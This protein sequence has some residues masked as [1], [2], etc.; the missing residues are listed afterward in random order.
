M[1][2][3]IGQFQ[4]HL[5]E[6]TTANAS[7][8]LTVDFQ[9]NG[10][11]QAIPLTAA[12]CVLSFNNPRVHT[13]LT[14]RFIQDATGG[15]NVTLPNI[16]FGTAVNLDLSPNSTTSCQLYWN[17]TNYFLLSSSSNS[18]GY[19]ILN[20]KTKT[21]AQWTDGYSDFISLGGNFNPPATTGFIRVP[22]GLSIVSRNFANSGNL[23]V[24]TSS[25]SIVNT[26][27]YGDISNSTTII[28][29]GASGGAGIN[30][31][32]GGIQRFSISSSLVLLNVP[33]MSFAVAGTLNITDL[34]S[35]TPQT[36][37]QLTI[38]GQN[39]IANNSTGGILLLKGGSVTGSG[40]CIGGAV[41]LTSGTGNPID[42]NINASDGYITFS[43]GNNIFASW[44]DG[45]SD[46][47][48]LA[49]T[50][51]SSITG[52]IRLAKN[53]TITSRNFSNTGDYIAYQGPTTIVGLQTFGDATNG[54]TTIQSG[55][56][57]NL[58]PLGVSRLAVNSTYT[59][60]ENSALYLDNSLGDSN[61]LLA[62]LPNAGGN[63]NSFT[64][65][66]AGQDRSTITSRGGA[67]TIRT[68]TG[69]SLDP[70]INASDGY[71]TLSRGSNVVASWSD[72]YSDFIS[73]GTG[74]QTLGA[75]GQNS[76]KTSTTGTIRL[77][78]AGT[79]KS[80][81]F[82]N[83]TDLNAYS[84]NSS[85]QQIFGDINSGNTVI[86][87]SSNGI[88]LNAGLS[89]VA[90]FNL[91]SAAISAPLFLFNSN[92]VGNATVTIND[93]GGTAFFNVTGKTLTIKSQNV[94]GITN[95]GG[96][97][98]LDTGTGVALDPN[99][100]FV[101]GYMSFS[102][103]GVQ[104]AGWTDGYSDFMSFGS[105]FNPTAT[106]GNI[107]LSN[108]G[109]IKSRNFL[110]TL[111]MLVYQGGTTVSNAQLFGDSS[112]GSTIIA[113]GSAGGAGIQLSPGGTQCLSVSSASV[114]IS[115]PL[116][117]FAS[118]MAAPLINQQ[119]I[120]A[121]GISGQTLT[122][123]SQS[124]T[125]VNSRG[126][127]LTISSGTGIPNS[128]A[129]NAS[130]GYISISR[131]VNAVAS[132]TDGYSDFMSFGSKFNPSAVTGNIRLPNNGLINSSGNLSITSTNISLI[133]TALNYQSM[134]G[135]LFIANATTIPTGNPTGGAYL[136]TDPADGKLKVRSTSGVTILG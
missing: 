76:P 8:A 56:G 130:D 97:L 47:I 10:I 75:T 29:S 9:T 2:G 101:D 22:A 106:T 80:R 125:G 6:F 43:R 90:G 45:Y 26:Q 39:V 100:N 23:S 115:V 66:V 40:N 129:I 48:S 63:S 108:T 33:L 110:N 15:R 41:N 124:T 87:S 34:F 68:G 24:Y 81:N 102:R 64:F 32:P 37:N 51:L 107:R 71:F 49:K 14:L 50:G 27:T 4:R 13:N 42:P 114:N 92:I 94:T 28:A 20:N 85:N 126:G 1:T 12:N 111:D 136:Y 78:F 60:L 36:G 16:V 11:T 5:N 84:Q 35:G 17:G 133:N 123:Q 52:N 88:I 120:A 105:K 65:T 77:P 19:L 104:F 131:G 38:S 59:Q 53:G 119:V 62:H 134:V 113:S 103:G 73:F 122:L 117:N 21:V 69:N 112:N 44:T 70:N 58:S 109:T 7:T 135:G 132:W 57:I 25:T 93:G 96:L 128:S 116:L 95:K 67:L 91:I 74:S 98:S 89:S 31:S 72:G 121:P 82:A 118:G 54:S 18:D 99:I 46:F 86:Q 127:T 30:L 3:T 79:I 55:G 83:N 61:V